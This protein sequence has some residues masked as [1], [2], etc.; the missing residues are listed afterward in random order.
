MKRSR[1][2][3]PARPRRRRAVAEQTD[4]SSSP[5]EDTGVGPGRIRVAGR[6]A[7]FAEA[8]A[9]GCCVAGVD[10]WLGRRL[11]GGDG[12]LERSVAPPGLDALVRDACSRLWSSDA[13]WRRGDGGD[14]RPSAAPGGEPVL[15]LCVGGGA[16]PLH[17]PDRPARRWQQMVPPALVEAARRAGRHLLV[18]LVAAAISLREGDPPASQF[19]P[20]QAPPD[21]EVRPVRE[22]PSALGRYVYDVSVGSGA[23]SHRDGS[24]VRVIHYNTHLPAAPSSC[25]VSPGHTAAGTARAIL[26]AEE[27]TALVA[28]ACAV[29]DATYAAIAHG[30]APWNTVVAASFALF[31]ADPAGSVRLRLFPQLA[32]AVLP[33]TAELDSSKLLIAAWRWSTRRMSPGASYGST[34]KAAEKAI[35]RFDDAPGLRCVTLR[36]AGGE[37]SS[38]APSV[39]PIG[40]VVSAGGWTPREVDLE[41][42]CD[43]TLSALVQGG[44]AGDSVTPGGSS[45]VVSAP[46]DWPTEEQARRHGDTAPERPPPP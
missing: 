32:R 8:L 31:P 1:S 42:L 29:A 25:L 41:N 21:V 13:V 38:L 28:E 11:D 37:G 46:A 36:V 4:T 12:S 39:E 44:G 22:L 43:A 23:S 24:F 40:E 45:P 3:V 17:W 33:H 20:H 27:A 26:H 35:R 30:L 19:V 2:P 18:V 10:A 9:G 16:G 14:R 34:S 6:S 15:Y 7:L 5:G